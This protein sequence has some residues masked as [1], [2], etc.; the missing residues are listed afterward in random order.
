MAETS[1]ET[2]LSALRGTKLEAVALP[3]LNQSWVRFDDPG[4]QFAEVLQAVGGRCVR[5]AGLQEVNEE[6][7]RLPA[8]QQARIIG[9]SVA[10]IDRVNFDVTAAAD[11]HDVEKLDFFVAP[12]EFAVAE[13][14]AVWVTSA[15]APH[16]VLFFIAQ[17]LALVVPA[18]QLLHNLH[19]AYQRLRFDRP[20]FGL[21]ISGPSKTADIEQSLVI[22]AHGAR[23]LTVFLV[24]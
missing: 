13:N 7:G 2:I 18:S 19:E 17:H 20:E 6:L 8:F 5:V 4:K 9:S 22:G 14:G 11:P 21:F 15:Q 23:S 16:R 10:G 24:G 1:K 3:D 12:G